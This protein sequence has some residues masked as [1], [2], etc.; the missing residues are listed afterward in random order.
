MWTDLARDY[1]LKPFILQHLHLNREAAAHQIIDK[2]CCRHRIDSVFSSINSPHAE[3]LSRSSREG[4]VIKLIAS[5]C[6]DGRVICNRSHAQKRQHPRP[7]CV[8]PSYEGSRWK[9]INS[10]IFLN[11]ALFWCPLGGLSGTNLRMVYSRAS[12]VSC[13]LSMRI[14][15]S[16]SS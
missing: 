4:A 15:A 3:R 11:D 8:L 1:A 9:S 5:D 14:V 2:L 16:R 12:F 6:T 10:N 13:L 7:Q